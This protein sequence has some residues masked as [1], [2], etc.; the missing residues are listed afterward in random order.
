MPIQYQI[1]TGQRRILAVA[2]GS[3]GE[4]D[5]VGYQQDIGSRP[6]L[7]GFDELIDLSLVDS[8]LDIHLSTIKHVADLAAAMEHD[9]PPSKLA[10][11][12][13]QDIY[14]GLGRMFEAFRTQSDHTRKQVSVFRSL[15]E[16]EQWLAPPPPR[17]PSP[18]AQ[19]PPPVQA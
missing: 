3:I 18:P 16:A 2:T 14:F 4:R 12:A 6:E 1:N 11:V 9:H 13:P 10:I 19:K 5:L 15:L 8:L 17:D 7:A